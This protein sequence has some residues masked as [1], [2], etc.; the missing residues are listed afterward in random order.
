MPDYTHFI[1]EDRT[2]GLKFRLMLTWGFNPDRALV[3]AA[4]SWT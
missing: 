2:I 4:L 3:V 1:E